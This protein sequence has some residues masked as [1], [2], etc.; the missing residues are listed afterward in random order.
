MSHR[1]L[2]TQ[3]DLFSCEVVSSVT[4]QSGVARHFW[5]ENKDVLFAAVVRPGDDEDLLVL[6]RDKRLCECHGKNRGHAI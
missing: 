2:R 4:A 1:G 3:S 6:V 5:P